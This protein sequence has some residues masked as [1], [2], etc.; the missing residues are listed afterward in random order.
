MSH[1]ANQKPSHQFGARLLV[2]GRD[3]GYIRS[4]GGQFQSRTTTSGMR[5]C[6]GGA[7]EALD[8]NLVIEI[9]MIKT[10]LEFQ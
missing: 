6:S 7:I 3:I 9:E 10:T 1:P 8:S 5:G 2:E 4:G